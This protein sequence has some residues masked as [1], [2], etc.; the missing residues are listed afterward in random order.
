M[1]VVIEREPCY[2]LEA[3]ELAYSLVNDIPA[4]KLSGT[5]L[6]CIPAE[7]IQRIRREAC[8]GIESHQT[9]LDF[10]FRQVTVG[11]E[12]EEVS[13]LGSCMLYTALKSFS[14]DAAQM[15]RELT[16]NWRAMRSRGL[17]ITSISDNSLNV[18][19]QDAGG[20]HPWPRKWRSCRFPKATGCSC[21]R[22]SALLT[23]T[24][25]SCC[26]F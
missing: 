24:W 14:S 17:R 7:A 12:G 8:A 5:G 4:E 11:A 22:R 1:D 23:P 16:Q 3:A 19:E 13:C 15:C 18:E 25:T 20:F 6:Y 9:A 21:W 2:L 10:Y 26:S